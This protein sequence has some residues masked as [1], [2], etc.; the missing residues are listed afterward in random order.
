MTQAVFRCAG[1]DFGGARTCGRRIVAFWAGGL[2]SVGGVGGGFVR[3]LILQLIFR[4]L[5]ICLLIWETFST[6]FVTG[7][8]EMV[9]E[10][11]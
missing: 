8:L 4:E 10:T 1:S 2:H 7:R 5:V 6:S 3:D 11:G 9:G